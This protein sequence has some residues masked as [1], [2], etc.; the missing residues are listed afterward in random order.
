[1]TSILLDSIGEVIIGS[2]DMSISLDELAT[3]D[4]CV[5]LRVA[6]VEFDE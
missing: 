5:L 1:M 3:D 4:I 2:V 6:G